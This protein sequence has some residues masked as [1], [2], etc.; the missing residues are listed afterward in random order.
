MDEEHKVGCAA[1]WLTDPRAA[2]VTKDGPFDL[3]QLTDSSECKA[4]RGRLWKMQ[5]KSP[6]GQKTRTGGHLCAMR[7]ICCFCRFLAPCRVQG[8]LIALVW[9]SH[10]MR[11]QALH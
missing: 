1:N 5:T 9:L 10:G 4:M 7:G 8:A 2:N 3:Q 11:S 6:R